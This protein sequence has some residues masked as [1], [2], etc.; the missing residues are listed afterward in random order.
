MQLMVM[1]AGIVAEKAPAGLSRQFVGRYDEWGLLYY[2]PFLQDINNLKFNTILDIG[3]W[4][5]C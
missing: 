1:N 2:T 5:C 3:R 4:T